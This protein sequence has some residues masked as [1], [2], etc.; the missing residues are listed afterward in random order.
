MNRLFY[1]DSLKTMLKPCRFEHSLRSSETAVELAALYGADTDKA[2]LAGLL[3]DIS[4]GQDRETIT[5]WALADKGVLSDYD[6]EYFNVLHS[7][8]SAGTAGGIWRFRMI[9]Y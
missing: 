9:R 1:I 5:A 7:Y 8:A 3:H 6:R 2:W 4:R